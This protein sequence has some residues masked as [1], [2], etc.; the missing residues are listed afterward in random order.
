MQGDAA[1]EAQ[2]KKRSFRKFAFRGVDL[3]RLLELD[4]D[5]LLDLFHARARRK[6]AA[7]S[8]G[9]LSLLLY[10]PSHAM[11]LQPDLTRGSVQASKEEQ[12][13]EECWIDQQ[14]PYCGVF[15]R[16]LSSSVY[17]ANCLGSVERYQHITGGLQHAGGQHG[18]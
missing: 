15:Q 13:P 5:A 16:L 3:E 8:W 11:R 14:A 1:A 12:S 17:W 2:P 4:L 10:C 9:L 18:F 7:S 6:C